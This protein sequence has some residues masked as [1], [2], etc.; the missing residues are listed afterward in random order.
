MGDDGERLA[1]LEEQ[2]RGMRERLDGAEADLARVQE[3][4]TG[5]KAARDRWLGGFV[6]LSIVGGLIGWFLT[7][8]DKLRMLVK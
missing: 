3:D 6:A 2:H 7:T 8:F 1:R 4:L 5:L